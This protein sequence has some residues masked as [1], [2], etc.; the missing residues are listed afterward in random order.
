MNKI[1]LIILLGILT[2]ILT[3]PGPVSSDEE[4][5]ITSSEDAILYLKSLESNEEKVL[6]L[7]DLGQEFMKQEKYKDAREVAQYVLEH[8]DQ[9]SVEAKDL[10]EEAQSK[11]KISG[12]PQ[13]NPVTIPIGP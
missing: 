8:L 4:E 9:N 1:I 5:I 11:E 3:G 6:Y 13:I 10:L 2:A 7:V 12:M